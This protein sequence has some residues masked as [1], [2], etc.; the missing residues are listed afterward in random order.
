MTI[1]L[2]LR[3]DCVVPI[4]SSVKEEGTLQTHTMRVEVPCSHYPTLEIQFHFPEVTELQVALGG[5]E[6]VILRVDKY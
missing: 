1:D 5:T 4:S 3:E 2:E 6:P